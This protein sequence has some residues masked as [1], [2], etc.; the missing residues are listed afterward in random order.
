MKYLFLPFL[1][2]LSLLCVAQEPNL[3]GIWKGTLTQSAGGCFPKYYIELQIDVSGDTAA[4]ASYHYS[5]ITNYVKK[6]F[7]GAYYPS[8][9]K[10]YLSE[11]AVQTFK[12]PADCIPCIKNYELWYSRN[13][14]VETLR[15]EWN[16]KVMNS[17]ASCQPGQLTLTRV[18]TSAFAEIPEVE[19]DTGMIRLDFY[20]NAEIDGDSISVRVNGATILTNKKLDITP[21]TAFVHIDLEHTFQEVEMVAV[22]LGRIPPNTALLIVTAGSKRYKLYLTSTESKSAKVRFIYDPPK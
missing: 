4:G 17:D 13:G 6:K 3:N 5:D 20:D 1:C 18:K 19:V 2:L 12:I 8:V 21:V 9:R 16:G 7:R 10:L 14:N 15:G 11:G 22:N